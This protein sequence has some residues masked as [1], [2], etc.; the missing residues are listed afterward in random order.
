MNADIKLV[1]ELLE[2][3]QK[4]MDEV[5]RELGEARQDLAEIREQLTR[6]GKV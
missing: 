4:G 5:R 3:L 1:L 6:E 2:D